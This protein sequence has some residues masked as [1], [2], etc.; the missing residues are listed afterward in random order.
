MLGFSWAYPSTG[1]YTVIG[2][3]V[4]MEVELAGES[5]GGG[6][7]NVTCTNTIINIHNL[8]EF[9]VSTELVR[10]FKYFWDMYVVNAQEEDMHVH[11]R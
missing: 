5:G 8:L 3:K 11:Q 7:P 6:H 9:S 10:H 1:M 4:G 2:W